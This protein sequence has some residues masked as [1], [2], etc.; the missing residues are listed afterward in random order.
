M[1]G[2][3][4]SSI[5]F[6]QMWPHSQNYLMAHHGSSNSN[7]ESHVPKDRKEQREEF[8]LPNPLLVTYINCTCT[9][10]PHLDGEAIKNYGLYLGQPCAQVYVVVAVTEARER[11]P[12]GTPQISDSVCA[13]AHTRMCV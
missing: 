11:D 1:S 8:T 13:C 6:C 12:W 9:L 10:G 2:T 3:Q 5:L 4:V 7:H